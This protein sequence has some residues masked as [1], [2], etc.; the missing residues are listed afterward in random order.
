TEMDN[1]SA[2]CPEA[3]DAAK[4]ALERARQEGGSQ[5]GY[6]VTT[7]IRPELQVAAR[8]AV[9]K[10]LDDYAVRHK[11][12][13]PYESKSIKAWGKPFKGKPVPHRIYVGV[14]QSV[15]DQAGRIDVQVGDVVGR[16]MLA[17]EERYNP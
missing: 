11:L 7:T 17:E 14:V 3:A 6:T 16:V 13:P 8:Q 15:D 9:R 12:E 4:K 10:A 2:L 5:G 1:Q